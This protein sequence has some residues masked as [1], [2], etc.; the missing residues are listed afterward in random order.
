MGILNWLFGRQQQG[1]NPEPQPDQ[2]R[3]SARN[4]V[5]EISDNGNPFIIYKNR[6]ITVFERDRGWK[7][8]VAKIEEDNDPYFSEVYFTVDAAKYEALAWLDGRPSANATRSQDAARARR[9]KWEELIAEK[10]TLYEELSA[11]MPLATSVTE[12]RKIERKVASQI[13]Q[14][15]WQIAEY[16]QAGVAPPVVKQ[17]EDLVEKFKAMATAVEDRVAEVKSRPVRTNK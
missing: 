9:E 1:A 4:P 6:R 10:A 3:R 16:H 14:G 7:Y 13:K 5:W 15:S 8:C 2:P 17:A 11:T 12:L